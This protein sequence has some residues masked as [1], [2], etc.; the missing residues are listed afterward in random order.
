MLLPLGMPLQPTSATCL[1]FILRGGRFPTY[2]VTGP[3][4]GPTARH[5][6]RVSIVSETDA[7]AIRAIFE[8]EGE[9][10]AAI[11]TRLRF[12]G[13]IGSGRARAC[14]CPRAERIR[15]PAAQGSKVESHA[16]APQPDQQ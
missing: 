12:L 5:L 14:L 10:S 9:L 1:S 13:I 15:T 4:C 8:Q 7:A 6:P 16:R 3:C 2:E 11:E